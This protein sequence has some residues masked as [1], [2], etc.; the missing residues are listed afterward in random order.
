MHR[1]LSKPR[2]LWMRRKERDREPL[3]IAYLEA[4]RYRRATYD[5]IAARIDDP[6]IMY[7]FDLGPD[8]LAVDVGAFEGKWSREVTARTPCRIDAFELSPEFFGVLHEVAEDIDGMRVF[9]YGLG[10]SN[11]T[12]QISRN[13][14]GSSVFETPR[15]TADTEWLE[16]QLRDVAQVWDELGWD[17]IAVLK[18]NIEGGEYDLLDRLIETGLIARVDCLFVQFHEWIPDAY[19]RRR[20]IRRALRATHDVQWSYD[21]VWEKWQR[22]P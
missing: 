6:G 21:W 7:T 15:T 19:P 3:A 11:E 8:D 10:G 5:F 4:S 14:L 2:Q 17:R 16:G 18:L 9:E 12:V 22:K 1:L 20:A 13:H